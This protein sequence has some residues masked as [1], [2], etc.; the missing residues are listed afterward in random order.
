MRFTPKYTGSYAYVTS[1]KSNLEF[2][3]HLGERR[4]Y[5]L[6]KHFVTNL[7]IKL[8]GLHCLSEDRA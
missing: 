4:L 1:V 7:P 5:F 3:F 8:L 6:L 2:S